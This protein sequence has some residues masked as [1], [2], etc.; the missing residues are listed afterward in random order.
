MRITENRLNYLAAQDLARGVADYTKA[1]R[2]MSTGARVE[3]PS[4]DPAAWSAAARARARATI[5]EAHGEAIATTRERLSDTE[6]SLTS[7]AD[8]LSRARE[9]ALRFANGDLDAG[10]RALAAPDVRSMRAQLLADLDRRASDGE[11]L[12]GG[13]ASDTVD[14]TGTYVGGSDAR[15]VEVGEGRTAT[16][17]VLGDGLADAAALLDQLASALEGNDVATIRTIIDPLHEAYDEAVDARTLLGDQVRAL[18]DAESVRTTLLDTLTA[19][20]DRQIA[21]DPVEAATALAGAQSAVE[22]A[23]LVASSIRETLRR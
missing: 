17:G 12:L 7:I 19:E 23:K 16:G 6:T 9:V 15:T 21:I 20:S 8:N 10:A 2:Q 4:D 14:G 13:D 3:K 18:E 11:P 5:N 1:A 22:G